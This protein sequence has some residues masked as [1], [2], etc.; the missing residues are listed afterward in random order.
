[1]TT[2]LMDQTPHN[3]YVTKL[4]EIYSKN[5]QEAK[6]YARIN[7]EHLSCHQ[8]YMTVKDD[9]I[10][11][12]NKRRKYGIS[13]NNIRY[14]SSKTVSFHSFKKG[15]NFMKDIR[16]FPI[17]LAHTKELIRG[18]NEVKEPLLNLYP[19]LRNFLEPIPHYLLNTP[20]NYIQNHKLY[21]VIDLAAKKYA[22][23][24]PIAKEL[25]E[26]IDFRDWKKY[27]DHIICNVI[28]PELK[29]NGIVRDTLEMAY[30]LDKK[31]NLAWSAKRLHQE[32]DN[33]SRELTYIVLKMDDKALKAF[34]MFE[35]FATFVGNRYRMLISTGQLAEEGSKMQ[36]CVASYSNEVQRGRSAIYHTEGH[37]LELRMDKNGLVLAQ[38]KGVRNATP[39]KELTEKILT[40]I[41]DFNE[42]TKVSPLV[43]RKEPSRVTIP[44]PL[45]VH[46]DDEYD[47][48]F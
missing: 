34:K 40:D 38:L 2:V 7:S 44:R 24:R 26:F 25:A 45:P 1:M 23:P 16:L 33:M 46:V 3:N 31:V 28:N 4:F 13:K 29:V 8:M 22:K 19:W 42:S 48:D 18:N 39:P 11:V 21:N 17:T 32:H 35:D 6:T 15:K 37:T 43:D 47:I 30:K 9:G 12:F 20:L 14:S 27:K 5:K 41:K 10:H 36:H